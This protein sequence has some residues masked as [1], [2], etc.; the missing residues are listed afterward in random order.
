MGAEG[1]WAGGRK[2]KAEE[3]FGAEGPWARDGAEENFGWRKF[4]ELATGGNFLMTIK[5]NYGLA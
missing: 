1:P 2:K 4:L 5:K 3:N